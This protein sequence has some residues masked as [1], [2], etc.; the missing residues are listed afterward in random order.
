MNS[1][2]IV[3]DLAEPRQ[4]LA[5]LLRSIMPDLKQID[6]AETRAQAQALVTQR[7]LGG[8]DLALVD[9]GLPDGNAEPLI[10][11]LTGI[12]PDSEVIVATIHDDDAH[13]FAALRAGA[14][15][16]ILK[17]QP[18]AVVRA[19]LQGILRGEP[20][21][22]PSVA[23]RV[24]RH[25]R[26]PASAASAGAV[27]SASLTRPAPAGSAPT[28]CEATLHLSAREV[29]VLR[30]IGKGYS[31]P[32]VARLLGI[33]S[34]TASSYVRDIYRKLG[35]SSRAEAAMEAARRGLVA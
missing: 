13:V 27:S 7:G 1:A 26:E 22:S 4:W 5:E 31:A 16:Y 2:L 6:L 14:T 9:W 19:Q 28:G 11:L 32:E 3:E 29:D 25:F 12:R 33:S 10:R 21:L 15:G 30:L 18:G 34:H 17:S 20:A 8:Y 24:L 23:L 35:I